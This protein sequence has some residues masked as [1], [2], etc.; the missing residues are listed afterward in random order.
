LRLS[1]PASGRCLGL[2]LLRAT[3]ILMVLFSHWISHFGY[4]FGVQIPAVVDRISDTGV[5]IFF[6]LSGFLIRRILIGIVRARPTWSD[7]RV[8]MVRRAMRTLPLYFLWL[9]LLLCVFPPRQDAVVTALRFLT[10]TQ[11]LFAA[12]P[13]DYYFV[14]TWSLTIEEWFYL[15]FGAALVFLSRRMGGARALW[16]CLAG[17]M[18]AP[19]A[20]RLIYLERGPPPGGSRHRFAGSLHAPMRFISFI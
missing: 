13:A 2:G 11:N 9:A 18:L 15:L 1:Q 16:W 6:A 10:L 3:A 20:L 14:V 5:E 7:F 19:L 12:M 8:F 17:F 4:W